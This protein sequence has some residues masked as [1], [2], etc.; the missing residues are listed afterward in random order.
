MS[1]RYTYVVFLWVCS[2]TPPGDDTQFWDSLISSI[3][4]KNIYMWKYRKC[5]SHIPFSRMKKP[6]ARNGNVTRNRGGHRLERKLTLMFVQ[7]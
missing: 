2:D 4:Y 6:R 7:V 1:Y 5:N 3:D